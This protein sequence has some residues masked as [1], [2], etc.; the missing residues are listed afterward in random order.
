MKLGMR[1]FILTIAFLVV[2]FSS[3]ISWGAGLYIDWLWFKSLNYQSV[4]V[5]YL[6]SELG[7]GFAVGIF[8]FLFL[9]VNLLFTRRSVINAARSLQF[10]AESDLEEGNVFHQIPWS[11]YINN[12]NLTT[13]FVVIS[14][15]LAYLLGKA[16]TGN[17]IILQKFLNPTMFGI[18]DPVFQKDIGFYVFSLPFYQFLYK[19]SMWLV[20]VAAFLVAVIYFL[21]SFITGDLQRFFKSA[22]VRYH[23]SLLGAVFFFVRAGGYQLQKYMLLYS[24]KGVVYGAGYADIHASLLAYKVLFYLALLT[25]VVLLANVFLRRFRLVLYSVGFL[26][27]ASI[28]LSG[29]YPALVQKLRVTPNEM[30][31]ERPYIEHNIKFTRL[32]YDLDKIEKK[33]F[34]AGRTL[35]LKDIQENRDIVQNIRLWDHRPLQQTYSQ[36]QEMRT[37]YEFKDIDVDRYV[38][39]GQYRQVMLS[40]RELNV[41]LLPEQAKTWVNM[42]LKFTHGYGIAMSP[43]NEVTGEGLPRYFV[44]DI[45]PITPANLKI[46]RPEIYYGEATTNYVIVKTRTQEFDY[47]LGEENAWTTYQ[48]NSGVQV[49]N[50]FRRALFALVL[51]DYKLLLSGDITNESLILFYRD[52]Q[53]RVP[54]IAP[55]LL[56]DKDPYIVAANGKL[57]WMW[58]A[59]TVSNMFP[60]AEPFKNGLNYIRNSV[61]VV[62]DAYTGEVTFYAVDP[63]EPLLKTYQK[64]FPNMFVPLAEMPAELKSHI[65]YPADLFT[66]QADKYAVY[67]MEDY[68]VF[69]NKEDKWNRA[70]ELYGRKEQTMDSYYTILKLEGEEKA[71]FVQIMPFT[72]QKKNNMIGWLTA[73]SD[74]ENYGKLLLYEFPKQELTFGPMQIET[75]INQN[76]YISQQISLWDQAGSQVIRGN[77]MVIPVKDALL[78]VEPLYLQTEKSKMPELRRVIVAHGEQIVME[79]TLDEAI[80]KLFGGRIDQASQPEPRAREKVEDVRTPAQLVQEAKRLYDE[81]QTRLA[82]RDWA[83]YGNNLEKLRALLE[84]L[85][86]KLQ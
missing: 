47:P 12:R 54:K 17:W 78:Y 34:P 65:R 81:A 49:S 40:A 1:W 3:F 6:F 29:V 32:A 76:A 52:I 16:A 64:I 48:A 42:H 86:N 46:E 26:I 53:T 38:I 59:Y 63:E 45:P 44:K 25:G 20:V 2:F 80:R 67:H 11:Q 83:G 21:P 68:R 35:T 10:E 75:R 33:D 24:E 58:D 39:D 4:F 82:Q 61:K 37:Y 18:A 15:I 23:L 69:Y 43:V 50:I 9:F 13:V 66:I 74:G 31:L 71:E 84:E 60:Y 7:I 56:Y 5:T 70:T 19:I 55:F 8:A 14:L 30:E 73:R 57:Y 27:V 85:A 62:V 28:A 41:E 36:L 77:M 22:D 72:P 79:P 51:K